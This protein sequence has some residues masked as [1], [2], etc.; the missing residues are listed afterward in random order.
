MNVITTRD[1]Q[2]GRWRLNVLEAGR[3]TDPTLLWLHGSGPGVSAHSNWA[4][5]IETMPGFH[6]LAPDVLGFADSEHPEDLPPGVGASSKVRVES[7]F[8]LLDELGIEKTHLVGNS[9]GGLLAVLMLQQ[10]PDRFNRVILMGSA[11][12]PLPPSQNLITMVLYYRNESADAMR[13]LLQLFMHDTSAFGNQLDEIAR[14]RAVFAAREDIRRSH[15]LTFTPE[16]TPTFFTAEQLAE[17]THEVLVVHGRE[18]SIIPKEASYHYAAHLPN[19]Q[20]HVLPHAGHW[21]Q[22]EQ[23]DRF[24]ALAQLFLTETIKEHS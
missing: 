16:K 1:I 21:V 11:G 13:D 24:R 12:A 8:A 23:V 19:A 15:E 2:A 20:L 10:Q 18:D 22:I 14:R 7:L 9:L 17:I 4:E 5:L 3:P 6:H